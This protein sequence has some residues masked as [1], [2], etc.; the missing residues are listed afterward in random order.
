MFAQVY[1]VQP[2]EIEGEV[3][4][5]VLIASTEVRL[6]F[7]KVGAL[8]VDDDH[9]PVH[10]SLTWDVEGTGNDS[11]PVDPVMAVPGE[12]LPDVSGDVELDA[13]AVVFDLVNPLSP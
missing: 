10:D 13:V 8:F 9:F 3:L 4:Q 12:G 11:E 6:K 5:S 7:G 2:Q 1:A